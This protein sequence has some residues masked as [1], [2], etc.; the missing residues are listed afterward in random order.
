VYICLR[1]QINPHRRRLDKETM[2]SKSR[3]ERV[4]SNPVTKTG[5]GHTSGMEGTSQTG[6]S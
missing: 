1:N 4:V 3:W 6:V 5:R 2:N